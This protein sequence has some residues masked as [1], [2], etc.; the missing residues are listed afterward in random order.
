M[1]KVQEGIGDKIGNFFQWFACFVAGIIIGFVYGW[2]LTL[3]IMA[4]APLLAACGGFMTVVSFIIKPFGT[5]LECLTFD[6]HCSHGVS[7]RFTK[8]VPVGTCPHC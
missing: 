3:V 1:N 7:G 4:F 6:K 5:M 2:K 8:N